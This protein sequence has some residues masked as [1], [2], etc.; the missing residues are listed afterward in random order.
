MSNYDQQPNDLMD[1]I[2]GG[3][4]FPVSKTVATDADGD[5]KVDTPMAY[6]E[7]DLERPADSSAFPREDAQGIEE[8]PQDGD[9]GEGP[10]KLSEVTDLV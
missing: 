3:D 2:A 9:G 5:G 10:D 1:E 6:Q 4:G 7:G 8:H